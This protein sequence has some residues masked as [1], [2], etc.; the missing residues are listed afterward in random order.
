MNRIRFISKNKSWAFWI[1]ST[2]EKMIETEK[3]KS[4]IRTNP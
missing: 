3:L 1:K 4:Q 2:T